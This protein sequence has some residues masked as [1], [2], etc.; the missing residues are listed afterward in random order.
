MMIENV[1]LLNWIAATAVGISLVLFVLFVWKAADARYHKKN[2]EQ[3]HAAYVDFFNRYRSSEQ[4][5]ETRWQRLKQLE[6][7]AVDL[8]AKLEAVRKAVAP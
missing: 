6:I 7:E 5:H 3:W 2:A 4:D 1:M 8:K